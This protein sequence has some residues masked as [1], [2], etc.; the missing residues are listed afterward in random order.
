[1][2]QF[3]K[4]QQ[5]KFWDSHDAP[6][7]AD[8][9]SDTVLD[10]SKKYIGKK[11]LDVGGG[12]GALLRA[13]KKRFK[14]RKMVSVDIAPN[15]KD[16]IQGDCTDLEFKDRSFDALF[17]LDVIEHLSDTDLTKCLKE[18]NRVLKKGGHGIFTTMFREKLKVSEVTCPDCGSRFHKKGHC[19]VFDQKR[20]KSIFKENGFNIVKMRTLNLGLLSNFKISASIMYLFGIDRFLFKKLSLLNTDMFIVVKKV[21]NPK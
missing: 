3:T 12:S 21:R 10:L 18:A 5:V 14:G 11:V 2:K 15:S 8:M 20:V 4:E 9:V 6:F 1:M 19:Q 7:K 16:V 13:F 17:C